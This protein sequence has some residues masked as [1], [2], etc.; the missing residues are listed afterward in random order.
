[1]ADRKLLVIGIILLVAGL[2]LASPERGRTQTTC[3]PI[4]SAW[5]EAVNLAYPHSIEP[6]HEIGEYLS[7]DGQ[8]I[9]QLTR[10]IFWS[11]EAEWDFALVKN[12]RDGCQL[13]SEKVPLD[14]ATKLFGVNLGWDS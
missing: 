10:L 14:K 2:W 11:K 7:I 6:V 4:E 5:I 3:V 12:Y 13:D 1:M 9:E 8:V